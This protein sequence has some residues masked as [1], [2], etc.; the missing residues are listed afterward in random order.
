MPTYHQDPARYFMQQQTR[1]DQ[2][3]RDLL[4]MF[5]MMKQQK[6]GREQ[7][8]WE[9]GQKEKEMAMKE[10]YYKG[11]TE[12]AKAQAESARAL[13]AQRRL[14]PQQPS[15]PY[16]QTPEATYD[17]ATAREDRIERKVDKEAKRQSVAMN[18]VIRRY[19]KERERLSKYLRAQ[20]EA[21]YGRMPDF[22]GKAPGD[23]KPKEIAQYQK[24]MKERAEL[25]SAQAQIEAINFVLDRLYNAK[26][27][28]DVG[29]LLS[30][31]TLKR[32]NVLLQNP[33]KLLQMMQEGNISELLGEASALEAKPEE[34]FTIGQLHTDEEGQQWRYTGNNKWE[35]VR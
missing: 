29:Q 1:R 2:Q 28:A 12:S 14:P 5:M 21:D 20:T 25:E 26:D 18:S 6:Y 10:P 11:L 27:K 35:S 7:T 34:E 16:W 33:A 32:L 23:L 4:N 9:R 24:S 15:V 3:I 30:P 19:E 13:A 8:M 22:G 17:R 31:A